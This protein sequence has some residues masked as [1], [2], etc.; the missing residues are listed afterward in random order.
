VPIEEPILG[1]CKDG[2]YEMTLEPNYGISM[3]D[4]KYE[5]VAFEQSKKPAG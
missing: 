1:V 5:I 3:I 2:R 4:E